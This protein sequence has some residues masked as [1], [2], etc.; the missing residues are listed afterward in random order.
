MADNVTTYTT[1]VDVE[2]KGAN[3]L[4]DLND[5]A[6]KGQEKFKSLRSQIR[7]TTVQLQA[8]ADAG[9]TGTKEF[10]Q[11]SDK[12]DDLGDQQKKVA[13]QSGQIEDKLAA[14]PGPIGQIGKGFAS[15]KEQVDTFGKTLTISLGVVGLLVTAFFAI[16]EALTKTKEGQEGLSKAMTAFNS[17]VAPLFALLEKVGLAILPIVT[18]GFEVLGQVM[19]KVAG[20]FGASNA[21]IKEVHTS[22]EK[23]NELVQ[24][25]AENNKKAAEDLKKQKEEEAKKYQETLAKNKA[26]REKYA[27]E[28]KR[29]QEEED[30]KEAERQKIKEEAN[31][32]LVNAYIVTLSQRDQEL[33]KAGQ[34]HNERMLALEKAGFKD[35]TAVLEQYRIETDAINKKFD[36]EAAKKV[37]EAKKKEEDAAKKKEEDDKKLKEEAE[38]AAKDQLDRENLARD[39]KAFLYQAE[40]DLKRANNKATYD[41]ELAL[42]DKTRELGLETLKANK[43]SNDAITAYEKQTA[44]VRIQ[45]EKAQQAAK[46][47][48][49]G[50]ALGQIAEAVGAQTTAGKALAIAQ[51]TI[52]TYLGATQALAT[53]P[54]PFGAIAAATVIIGGLLQVKKIVDTK[55]PPMP[56]PGGGSTGGGGGTSNAPSMAAPAIP[57]MTMPGITATGGTNPTQQIA[58]TLSQTTNKPV[59]AYVVSGDVSSQQALDRRTSKAATF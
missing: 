19:S 29:K 33:F 23:N 6:E 31:K 22:L 25:T 46:L 55:I 21:K 42:Y 26:A 12:L 48:V 5:K 17:V 1:V 10:Q 28:L 54:P 30:K 8:L 41:D 18:K 32:V 38:K 16:K 3:D 37:E 49:I 57:S 27:A 47:A 51:A 7:E 14:L 24:K 45:I 15:L 2:V 58:Q 20:F 50:D 59:K 52:N 44:A 11:L 13:F 35:K 36:D 4:G 40:F 39:D 53:Y 9:K 43:A 34:A 56:V